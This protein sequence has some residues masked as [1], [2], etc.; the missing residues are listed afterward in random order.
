MNSIDVTARL[1][2]SSYPHSCA[3]LV[4][5]AGADCNATGDDDDA[6]FAMRINVKLVKVVVVADCKSHC[7]C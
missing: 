2:T 4:L 5:M 1:S 6:Q 7:G 3:D